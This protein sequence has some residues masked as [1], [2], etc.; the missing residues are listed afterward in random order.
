MRK[1]LPVALL[2]IFLAACGGDKQ[3][4]SKL[5]DLQSRN[6]DLNQRI[7]KLENDLN[8]TKKQLIQMQQTVQSMNDRMK[9]VETGMDKLTYAGAPH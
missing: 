3:T 1:T 4:A 5:A 9:V 6:D 8:D 7:T 2:L